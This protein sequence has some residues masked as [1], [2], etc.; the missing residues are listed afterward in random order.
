MTVVADKTALRAAAL[1]QRASV[2]VIQRLRFAERLAEVGPGLVRQNSEAPDG[3]VSIYH[4][5]RDEIDTALLFRALV[6]EGIATA[7]PVTVGRRQP[8]R[9]HLWRPGDPVASGSW[10]IPEPLA[11]ADLVNPDV[12]FVP[13][14]AFDRRGFRLG[15]GAGYYDNS[16]A[17]LRKL[18]PVMAIGVAF[19]VQEVE[20]VPAEPH[21]EPLDAVVTEHDIILCRTC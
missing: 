4:P 21:D 15:Y 13:L 10:G 7:L 2:P 16:L 8:L 11:T 5:I 19:A 1:A 20:R 18:K 9:F 3:V 12:L 14:A 17:A 6:R